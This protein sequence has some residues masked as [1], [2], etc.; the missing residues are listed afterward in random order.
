MLRPQFLGCLLKRRARRRVDRR[1]I[2]VETLE[3]RAV[4]ALA[5]V[6][7]LTVDRSS[8]DDA[9]ILVQLKNGP[10]DPNSLAIPGAVSARPLGILGDIWEIKLADG[11]SATNAVE[12]ARLSAG[13]REATFNY[14]LQITQTPNDPQ[15]DEQWGWNNTGQTG[16]TLDSDIDAPEAWNV[17]TGSPNT[18]V[19]VI[20]TGI[21]YTHPDLAGNI[22]VNAGEI[23][24]NG[25]DDDGNGFVDDIH[26][27]DFA[28]N[29]GDPMDDHSHGTHVAGTI[30]AVG[31]N[32]LGVTGVNWNVRIMALKFLDS[33]GNGTVANAIRALNYAVENGAT[34]SNNSY[35]GSTA[36]DADPLFRDAIQ[37]AANFGHIFVAGAGNS[38]INNDD[39]G[40]YPANFDADNIISVAATDHNDNL[41]FFSNYGATTVDIAAPGVDILSTLPNGQYGLNSGTSMASP[42]VAGVMALVRGL[43]PTWTYQQVIDRVLSSVDYVPSLEGRVVT[44]G[45]LNAARALLDLDGPRIVGSDPAGGVGGVVSNVRVYFNE[46]VNSATFGLEDVAAFTGPSGSIAVTGVTVVPGSFDRKFDITFAPQITRGNYQLVLGPTI[47]DLAGNAMDQDADGVLGEAT[48][49]RFVATFT[50]GDQYIFNSTDTP[51]VLNSLAITKSFLNVTDDLSI[52]DLDVRLSMSALDVGFLNATIISPTGARSSLV[53]MTGE[54]RG[55][56]YRDTTFSDEALNTIGGGGSPYTGLFRPDTPLSVMDN[57]STRGTWTLEVL[58][59][60]GGT[61]TSWSLLVVANPP[62][63]TIGDVEVAEGDSGSTIMS[64]PVHLSNPIDQPVTIEYSTADG[65]ATAGTDYIA[66]NG[67][68]IFNPGEIEKSITV[69]V[70]GDTAD[71]LDETIQLNLSNAINATLTDNQ[72]VGTIK[73]DERVVSIGDV[74][75]AEVNSGTI[76]ASFPVT[77]SAPSSH[78]VTV[79]YTTAPGTATANSD[80][81]PIT[82]SIT[83]QPGET[84]RTA[85]VSVKGDTRYEQNETFFVNITSSSAFVQDAQGIGTILNDDPLPVMSIGDASVLEGNSGTKNLV[86]PVSLSGPSD[87]PV[88]VNFS[89][90]V[91]TAT[92]G[93]DYTPVTGTLTFAPGVTNYNIAVPIVGDTSLEPSETVLMQLSSINNAIL[94]DGL[95]V[96]TILADD[97]NL[98]IADV[99]VV[100]GDNGTFA[101]SFTVSLSSSVPFEVRVNYGTANGTAN[102]GSDY[103]ASSGTVIF[104][105]GETTKTITVQGISDLRNESQKVF[106]LNLSG[107]VNAGITDSQGRATIDDNDPLPTLTISDATIIEGATGTR[108]LSFTLSLSSISGQN[109]TVSYGT[110]DVTA[111][112][113]TDYSAAAGAF[114]INAGSK[115]ATLRINI[116]G[117]T[118]SEADELLLVNLTNAMNATLFDDQGVGMIQD[119]DSLVVTDPVV[120][121]GDSGATIAQF[122]VRLQ[123]PRVEP[124]TVDFATA[125]GTASAG[126]DY[127]GRSGTLTFEPG[128]SEKNVDI[129]VIGDRGNESN[130]TILLNLTNA[131]G[132]VIADSQGVATITNDDATPSVSITDVQVVEG[133]SS[134]R[135]AVF[136]LTLSQP[137]NQN[138]SIV[139][140]TADGTATTANADYQPRSGSVGFGIGS[141]LA[142]VSVPVVGDIVDE[143]DET[144]LLNLVSATNASLAVNQAVATII[145]DDP[146]PAISIAD[147]VTL[148]G[149]SGTKT[150]NF[151]VTLSAPSTQPVTV[152][153]STSNGTATAGSDY[154]ASTQTVTF[155]PGQTSRSVSFVLVGDAILEPTE[156]FVVTLSN[157]TNAILGDMEAI[158]SIQNDDSSLR[159]NDVTITET[160][161]GTSFVTFVVSLT[162][163]LATSPVAVNYSTTNGTAAG[164]V[165]YVGAAGLLTFA[166][167]ETSKTVEVLVAGDLINEVNETLNLTLQNPVNAILADA[168]GVATIVDNNDPIPTLSIVDA[169]VTEGLSGTK[170]LVLTAKLS[171]INGK[172]VTAS[173]GT[174]D[175]TA[176]STSDYQSRSGILTFGAGT[177]S[178]Q[179]TVPIVGDALGEMDE[180]FFVNLTNVVNATL[181]DGQAIGTIQDDDS[182]VVDDV[183]IGEGDSGSG[184]VTFTIR[185]LAARDQAVSVD[186]ATANAT[187]AAGSDYLAATGTVTFAPG[188]TEKTVDVPIIGDAFDESDETIYLNLS[189]S[190]GAV[191]ADNRGIATIVDDD[192]IPSVTI[193]NVM[194]TESN[195]GTRTITFTLLLSQPSGQNV[196]VGYNTSD[197]TASAS[198]GD[199][200]S[201]SGTVTFGPGNTVQTIAITVNGDMLTE[202]NE[203]FFLNL[204]SITNGTLLDNQAMATIVDD[205]G[206]FGG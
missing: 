22:W 179:I 110:A 20:D 202:S 1:I 90:A 139:Y 164:G 2:R 11:A 182:L 55:P 107:A 130:E 81:V 103:I 29:D 12:S 84:T 119:D 71:E 141:T 125:N 146:L 19:A 54:E 60:F 117:D 144:F 44:A 33:S 175:G 172:T 151:T 176:L 200:V 6:D 70:S 100:E 157:P 77:L 72:A 152:V 136:T 165:D 160:D 185:L 111:A 26:G 25:I 170:N 78:A 41:A 183:T 198:A 163:P 28:N 37:S 206:G 112:A 168:T 205:D 158:G 142:T 7:S 48:Q 82:G 91:G 191:I 8:Y 123:T 96:G 3:S 58:S 120:V 116:N 10:Y 167:G 196:T 137:S 27:Y 122:T 195:T 23:A 97:Q 17:F 150:L 135:N 75:V 35:G 105:P 193:S 153:A 181:A 59:L 18:I 197:G 67:T 42:H 69:V 65:T 186:Y 74:T 169:V 173:Y 38:S 147:A 180:N 138:I 49:D 199:Y 5:T 187:A 115:S 132:T 93:V 108:S 155:S 188:E 177:I 159:V 203:T 92:S 174:A 45:R 124:V 102:A 161:S 73:N 61:L 66:A 98:S 194:I 140:T 4:P 30:G 109:V 149:N 127:L 101:T 36:E 83:F 190:V 21:D 89:S 145:D 118:T 40:F 9:T 13:V 24:G 15:F 129:V 14:N 184:V 76:S 31:N 68:L 162:G 114:T 95:A 47:S 34:I 104:A 87:F 131:V 86:F 166:P 201:R 52:A 85:V 32:N 99:N 143:G 192:A 178:Q 113:G 121:E 53:P 156:S 16:G 148:E 171:S 50:L 88:T 51:K 154:T 94:M 46:P 62:R 126:T 63:V 64:F 39:T 133:P 204:V 106:Y 79:T 56:E 57:Q 189:N 128:E 80:Y 43:H 134:T